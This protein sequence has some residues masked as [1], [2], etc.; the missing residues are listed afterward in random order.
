MFWGIAMPLN[1]I[2]FR[3][4]RNIR[5]IIVKIR[6]FWGLGTWEIFPFDFYEYFLISPQSLII[7][8]SIMGLLFVSSWLVLFLSW[9]T[10]SEVRENDEMDSSPQVDNFYVNW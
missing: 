3:K 10:L 5:L 1:E 2:N 4:L 9:K 6:Y 7:N 8:I